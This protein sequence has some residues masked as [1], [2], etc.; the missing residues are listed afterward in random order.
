MGGNVS[1]L[2]RPLQTWLQEAKIRPY[3][4]PPRLNCQSCSRSELSKSDQEKTRWQKWKC[5]TFQPFV[6]NYLVGS[7][8]E[9]KPLE[10]TDQTVMSP[11]G[12]CPS[13][14]YRAKFFTK[15][16][17]ERGEDLICSFY[18]REHNICSNWKNRPSECATYFCEDSAFFKAR[19]QDLFDWEMAVAQ[20]ALLEHGFTSRE[21]DE[22][23]VSMDDGDD[24]KS[25]ARWGLYEGEELKFYSSC[26]TWAKSLTGAE[27][28]SWLPAEAKARF[29]SWVRFE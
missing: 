15:E 14:A 8:L 20:M 17:V 16:D 26:W 19:S 12:L 10:K 5:C 21:I 11:V 7:W 25:M 24:K 2:N 27:I 4:V 6:A 28:L 1:W 29:D 13:Y 3:P 9:S 22:M 23:L 18:D